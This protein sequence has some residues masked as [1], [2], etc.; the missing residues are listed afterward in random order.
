MAEASEL[1]LRAPNSSVIPVHAHCAEGVNMY[2]GR[3][4]V[5]GAR[6]GVES[7]NKDDNGDGDGE[8]DDAGPEEQ[9]N[10]ADET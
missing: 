10:L 4:G 3:E 6:N 2:E 1:R 7:E 8:G 5:S 9:A